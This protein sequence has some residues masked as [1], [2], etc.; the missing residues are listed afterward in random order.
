MSDA[1][2]MAE[3]GRQ[4]EHLREDVLFGWLVDG[5]TLAAA[6]AA[7]LAACT[8]CQA[9]AAQTR[10]LLEELVVYRAAVPSKDAQARYVAAFRH[11]RADQPSLLNRVASWLIGS[12][13]F[14]SRTQALAAGVR[15]GGSAAYRL[16]FRA[17]ETELELLV[18]PENGRRSLVGEV[19]GAV[20]TVYLVQL[21]LLEGESP[22]LEQETDGNGMFRFEALRP[23]RY[24]L[25]VSSVAGEM[26]TVG[27]LMLE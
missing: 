18:E 10:R 13:V 9:A 1:A 26:F 3:Q 8:L 2:D 24:R 6:E 4:E 5:Q 20:D 17:G 7:H 25:D 14:D 16:V 12:L 21:S 11:A 23:G 19:L 22:V 27:E 15:S